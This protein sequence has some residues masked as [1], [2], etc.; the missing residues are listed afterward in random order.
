VRSVGRQDGFAAAY[1]ET[2]R[3]ELGSPRRLRRLG[4]SPRSRVWGA[5]I[6]AT[7]VVIKQIV[8]GADVA[9]RYAL[10]VAAL[11]LA[12]RADR[13]LPV[14][15]RLL[16]TDPDTATLVLERL[17]HERPAE[18][19][20]VD[21]AAAL[22]RLHA[23]GRHVESSA[24]PTWS[25]PTGADVAAIVALAET[26]QIPVTS[27]VTGQL[28]ELVSR[29]TATTEGCL[30]HG[31]PCPDNALHTRDGVRFVDFE[32]AA[33]GD[34]LVELA[35]LRIGFPTCWC[36][37]STPEPLLL[38]AEQAYQ[39][40][41]RTA[42]GDELRTDLTAACIGWLLRGDALVERAERDTT[43]HFARMADT[44]W[45]WGTVTARERLVFRLGVVA[46]LTASHPEYAELGSLT[47]A[48]RTRMLERWPGLKPPPR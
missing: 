37:T 32:Q 2:L 28:D 41:W 36:V 8:G 23:L 33:I 13:E 19:W 9:Q 40:A 45:R 22:A 5:D 39:A 10:E 1:G 3:A 47:A 34:G 21:Y 14:A 30:L 4:S 18:G 29:L 48:I 15:P 24:L 46:G 6:A 42:T 12:G 25:G 20:Q 44:D 16:A 17:A 38:R 7:P 43:D 31:D 27:R 26:L 11:R 35:Y